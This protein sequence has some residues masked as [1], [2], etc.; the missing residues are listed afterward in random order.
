VTVYEAFAAVMEDVQA[1]GKDGVNTH[2][3]YSFR[4]VDAVMNAVGPAL[5]KHGVIIVPTTEEA[6]YREVEVGNNRTLMRECT[7]RVRYTVY[8]PEGDSFSGV[9]YGESMDSGDKGTP[10]AHSVAFRTFLLQALTIPTDEPD[11]DSSSVERAAQ[12]EPAPALMNPKKVESLLARCDQLGISVVEIVTR[13]TGGRTHDPDELL[14][15]DSD[16]VKAALDLATP[17]DS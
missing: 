4:G 11:P 16:G 1:V 7:V 3:H 8:G 12:R 17:G 5:R 2:Q 15:S 10:K 9:V 6:N 13:A 14:A